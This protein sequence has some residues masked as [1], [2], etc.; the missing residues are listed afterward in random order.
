MRKREDPNGLVAHVPPKTPARASAPERGRMML[1]Q[2][3][4]KTQD[5]RHFTLERGVCLRKILLCCLSFQHACAYLHAHRERG[6]RALEPR[7]H[8]SAFK[9][10]I[11]SARAKTALLADQACNLAVGKRVG[12]RAATELQQLQEGCN[13]AAIRQWGSEWEEAEALATVTARHSHRCVPS[14]HRYR[15][16]FMYMYMYMY[17]YI[18]CAPHAEHHR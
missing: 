3:L 14:S 4:T 2:E 17:I 8:S 5:T 10:C 6:E 11:Q 15:L 18:Y 12:G 16:I 7:H 13:R 1:K 9:T